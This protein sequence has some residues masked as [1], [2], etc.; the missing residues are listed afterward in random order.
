MRPLLAATI[1]DIKSD[2]RFPCLASPKIDGIRCLAVEGAA[3]SRSF[4]VIP[5][6]TVQAMFCRKD[7]H[8]LD[9]EL[10]IGDPRE[11]NC[12][13]VTTSAVMAFTG[14]VRGLIYWVFDDFS[15]TGPYSERLTRTA[16]RIHDLDLSWV[17]LV[18]QHVHDDPVSLAAHEEE[19]VREGYEGL[20][21]RGLD[22]LYKQGR[23][24]LKEQYLMKLKR[25]QD[26]E[27]KC[28]GFTELKRN[29]NEATVSETGYQVRSSHKSNMIGGSVLG[30][31]T[32]VWEPTGETFNVGT[33]FTAADREFLW[34]ARDRL[35]GRLVKFKYQPHGV[36]DLPRLPVFVGFRS[37]ED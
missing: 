20:M 24:T 26:A 31:L 32:C 2:V 25:F 35:P 10:T 21:V 8:G 22:G 16:T 28:V 7:F 14:D 13:N 9:G 30:A 1:S 37:V 11:K 29:M 5:N 33:G 34:A 4:K 15:C 19:V 36:K 17:V 3:M 12:F 18:N 27:A 23:S 6:R